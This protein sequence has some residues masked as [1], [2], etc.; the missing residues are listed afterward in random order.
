MRSRRR[1]SLFAAVVLVAL[2]ALA[3]PAAAADPERSQHDRVVAYWTPER[4]QSATPRGFTYQ[5]G[6]FVP[7]AKPPGAGGGG[8]GGSS[9][10]TGAQWPDFKG[11]IYYATGRVY[12]T[13]SSGNY[14]CSGAVATEGNSGR[15]IVLTAAH[16]AY[17]GQAGGFATNWM[18][19]P[20]FDTNP[21]YT[22]ANTVHGC[23]TATALVVHRGFANETGFTANAT[24]HDWAFAVVESGGKLNAQLDATVGSFPIA[25]TSYAQNTKM[26]ATGYPAGGKYSPGYELIYCSGPVAFDNWNANRTYKLGCNMTGGSSGGPWLTSFDGTGDTGVLSSVN[27]YTYSGVKAMHGPKFDSKTQATWNAALG[28]STNVIVQ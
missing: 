9:T 21:T 4:M 23:W 11:K 26:H 8:G 28:A 19:I 15:S 7:S 24:L 17:D 13:L 12:F 1:I 14:I 2:P 3:A 22:C 25:F 16:C 27:S 6:R 20:E 10:V 18:F 5:Q